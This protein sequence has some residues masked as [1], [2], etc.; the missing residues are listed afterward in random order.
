MA[1]PEEASSVLAIYYTFYDTEMDCYYLFE[2]LQVSA[3]VRQEVIFISSRYENTR[4][5]VQP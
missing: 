1:V 4:G 3:C 2:R 5:V